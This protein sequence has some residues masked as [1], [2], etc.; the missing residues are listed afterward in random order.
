MPRHAAIVDQ[1]VSDLRLSVDE[2]KA[3]PQLNKE[4][5]CGMYGMVASIPDNTIVS[6]FII[7]FFS[8]LY[9]TDSTSIMKQ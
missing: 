5:S 1:L 7:E 2:V 8:A 4:G 6:D 9:K 3:N